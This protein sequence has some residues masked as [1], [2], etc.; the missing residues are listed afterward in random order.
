MGPTP[1]SETARNVSYREK[2]SQIENDSVKSPS[3]SFE[4]HSKQPKYDCMYVLELLKKIGEFI[5]EGSQVFFQITLPI[6]HTL[7]YWI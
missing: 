2:L 1:F 5:L 7:H 6:S 3:Q 4:G